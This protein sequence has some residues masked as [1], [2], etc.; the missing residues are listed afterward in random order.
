[1]RKVEIHGGSAE[2]SAPTQLK[3]ILIVLSILTVSWRL[4]VGLDQVA[5]LTIEEPGKEVALRL[6]L[7]AMGLG[8]LICGLVAFFRVRSLPSVFFAL[9]AI[10]QAIHWGGPLKASSQDLQI[11]IWL[12]YF[13]ISMLGESFLL[14]FALLFPRR[15]SIASRTSTRLFLY[16][17]VALAAAVATAVVVL[18]SSSPAVAGLQSLFFMLE[19]V[20]VN[21]YALLTIIV[22]AVRFGR[23]SGTDRR[24][25]GLGVMLSGMV[26]GVLP[27]LAVVVTQSVAPGIAIPGGLG[28]QSYTLFFILGPLALTYALLKS[29]G[30]QLRGS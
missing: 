1:M 12:L 27:Y 17:P 21:L 7:G 30:S 9:H 16:L 19:A 22:I 4:S 3:W 5:L 2:D 8:Y 18:P 15:W 20:Q 24:A 11:A 29:H 13:T 6:V 23:A 26:V 28:S 25:F 10:C 14:Y